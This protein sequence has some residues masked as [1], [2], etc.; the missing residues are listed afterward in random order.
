MSSA[1]T[2]RRQHLRVLHQQDQAA[3]TEDPPLRFSQH[4]LRPPVSRH[5]STA[6]ACASLEEG[7]G[8]WKG[9]KP[10]RPLL[11]KT[12]TCLQRQCRLKLFSF[13]CHTYTRA[14]CSQR[15][16]RCPFSTHSV[17]EVDLFLRSLFPHT[18]MVTD[19]V[20]FGLPPDAVPGDAIMLALSKFFRASKLNFTS[21]MRAT[22]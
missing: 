8:R 13:L 16:C 1:P 22:L 14:L 7:G 10:L 15:T 17:A 9:G 4:H 2:G 20:S 19:T 12:T 18:S 21:E 11:S 6:S 3:P 5:T